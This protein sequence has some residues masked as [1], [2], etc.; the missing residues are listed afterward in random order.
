MARTITIDVGQEV[1]RLDAEIRKHRDACDEV[2]A[3][4]IAEDRDFTADETKKLEGEQTAIVALRARKTTLEKHMSLTDGMNEPG[5]ARSKNAPAPKKRSARASFGRALPE[6]TNED[7]EYREAFGDMVRFGIERI[8]S[9]ARSILSRGYNVFEP[10]S[11]ERRDLSAFSGVDGGYLV[12]QGFLQLVDIAEK[13]YSG[14]L[15]AP[16]GK[17]TTGKGDDIPYPTIND[18][19]NEGELVNENTDQTVTTTTS[20]QP[21]MGQ[22]MLKAFLGSSKLVKV[23]N[24]LLQDSMFDVGALMADLFAQRLGRLK[25]RVFTT[26]TGANQPKGIMESTTLG[27]TAASA[28]AIAFTETVD[29]MHSIDESYR[30]RPSAGYMFNDLTLGLLRKLLATDGRPIW[31]PQAVAGMAG[32]GGVGGLLNNM[33]YY[34]NH[35][36]DNVAT[37]K[38]SMIFGDLATYK[39]RTISSAVLVRLNERFAEKFQT[40]FFMFERFDGRSVDA[41]LN[42]VKHLVHP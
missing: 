32:V 29:L 4:V 17:M 5:E 28:T 20:G 41:S 6:E 22:V 40:G 2:T 35:S 27:K 30:M 42:A 1:N 9:D 7:I 18:T 31:M 8:G 13:S 25:N 36:M 38:K 23:P 16:T 11:E 3:R 12:P 15:A 24:A 37:G 26:G 33:P 39:I 34:V 10:E 19:D 21:T 14:M